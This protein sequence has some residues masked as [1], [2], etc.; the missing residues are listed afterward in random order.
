SAPGVDVAPLSQLAAWIAQ[1]VTRGEVARVHLEAAAV[2]RAVD[3]GR[4]TPGEAPDRHAA[5]ARPR[6][7]QPRRARVA[8]EGMREHGQACLGRGHPADRPAVDL[9]V[10]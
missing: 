10:I 2:L 1:V 5:V 7:E 9:A 6:Q 8:R 4:D 3:D